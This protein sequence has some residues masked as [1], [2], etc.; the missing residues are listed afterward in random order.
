MSHA[1][2]VPY[3]KVIKLLEQVKPV[4][5]YGLVWNGNLDDL[6]FAADLDY[7]ILVIEM[8]HQGFSVNDLKISLQFLLSRKRVATQANLQVNLVPLVRF[9]T[10]SRRATRGS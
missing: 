9:P 8:E 5:S 1:R 7:D 10:N 2:Q 3:N 4:F 6:T